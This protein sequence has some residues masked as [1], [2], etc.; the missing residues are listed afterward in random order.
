LQQKVTLFTLIFAFAALPLAAQHTTPATTEASVATAMETALAR[1]QEMDGE[2]EPLIIQVDKIRKRIS[3]ALEDDDMQ[4][5]ETL[6]AERLKTRELLEKKSNELNELNQSL[7]L[8]MQQ[9]EVG[10]WVNLFAGKVGVGEVVKTQEARLAYKAARRLRRHA[11]N[12]LS[13]DEVQFQVI[14]EDL[15][16]KKAQAARAKLRRQALAS[17]AAVIA[18]LGL[19]LGSVYFLYS[20]QK[21]LETMRNTRGPITATP[22]EAIPVDALAGTY[23]IDGELGRGAMGVVFEAT[24]LTLNRKV[25]IKQMREELRASNKDLQQFL[26]E[27]RTV[28]S[29]K[30]PNIVDIHTVFQENDEVYLVF[31]FV[32]G[33]SLAET[34]EKGGKLDWTR[35]LELL[36]QIGAALDY[37][38]VRKVIHRDL[39]PDNIMLTPTGEAKVMDFG[40][41]HRVSKTVAKQTKASSWG[42]PPYMA[43]EQELGTVS[44]ESDLYAL[45]VCMYEMVTGEMPFNGPNF[46]A[47]KTGMHFAPASSLNPDLPQG[48]DEL[49]KKALAPEAPARFHSAAELQAALAALKK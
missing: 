12:T 5:V 49:L 11:T 16:R 37:A 2:I 45:A 24:D 9:E 15:E 31:E 34:I 18:V 29:F 32:S 25:A 48:F 28:A 1:A 22:G 42:T 8:A 19:L 41:A 47:Q 13:K 40:I 23:R 35:A 38:H 46:L 44:R 4:A 10:T 17:I 39:K 43:P 26:G 6:L 20:K 27:A 33:K 36:G 14:L 3:L 7:K 21:K 30:H